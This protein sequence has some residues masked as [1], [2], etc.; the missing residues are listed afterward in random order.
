MRDRFPT[1]PRFLLELE[2][3]RS[4]GARQIIAALFITTLEDAQVVCAGG[5]IEMTPEDLLEWAISMKAEIDQGGFRGDLLRLLSKGFLTNTHPGFPLAMLSNPYVTR[6]QVT[7]LGA[8]E[9]ACVEY[10][11]GL[12]DEPQ[13]EDFLPD[14]PKAIERECNLLR[15]EASMNRL[16]GASRK[17]EET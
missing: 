7:H 13:I 4:E 15:I 8:F 16:A 14:C 6:E 12:R 3:D 9:A 1:V 10:G 5:G 11:K 2:Q 17:T